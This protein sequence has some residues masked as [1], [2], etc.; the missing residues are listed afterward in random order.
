[1][2][3]VPMTAPPFLIFSP[4]PAE[5]Y[6]A[7]GGAA[8]RSRSRARRTNHDTARVLDQRLKHERDER[9]IFDDKNV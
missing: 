4:A 6:T 3:T 8:C 1:L 5:R 9:L 7:V 2:G